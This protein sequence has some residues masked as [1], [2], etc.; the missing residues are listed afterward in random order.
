MGEVGLVVRVPLVRLDRELVGV[1]HPDADGAV[2]EEP[3]Q[4]VEVVDQ[5]VADHAARIEGE[6]DILFLAPLVGDAF[7]PPD[8]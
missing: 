4:L 8:A 1:L 6:F 3:D 5:H 2:T 7:N